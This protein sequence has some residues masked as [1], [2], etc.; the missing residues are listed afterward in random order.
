VLENLVRES[1][2]HNNRGLHVI[3]LAE[4]KLLKLGRGHESDVRIAD[5]SI[6]R[7]HATIRYSTSANGGNF[8][9]EDH[10][11]KFGTLVVIKKPKQMDVGSAMSVQVGRTVLQMSVLQNEADGGVEALTGQLRETSLA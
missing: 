3:S 10:S 7:C 2:Q 9:L 11:S 1:Q 5:V 6:S 4:K 8:I